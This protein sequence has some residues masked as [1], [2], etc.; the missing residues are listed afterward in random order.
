MAP[1]SRKSRFEDIARHAGVGLATVDRVLNERGGVSEKTT[2]KVLASARSLGTK[3]VLPRDR[4]R[5]L[6]IEAV[7]FRHHSAFYSRLNQAL[8]L[9]TKLADIPAT[10]YRTHIDAGEPEQFVSHLESVAEN[11]DGIILFASDLPQVSDAINRLAKHTTIVTI[12]TDIPESER[13][14][15]IGIDNFNAGQS[16]AKISEAICRKGGRILVIEPEPSARA[17]MERFN[18]FHQFFTN[19]GKE[20]TLCRFPQRKPL[21]LAV[22][23]VV[24]FLQAQEDVRVLYSPINN[25][26]LEM[27]VEVGRHETAISSVAKIVHDLSPHS[28]ENLQSGLIDIVLD[29]NPMQQAFQAVE[30]IS[31]QHGHMT[32]LESSMVDF[33]LYTS[34]NLP[35][36]QFI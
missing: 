4:K 32:K 35:R 1:S 27:L 6:S 18:G 26:F 20:G 30:F 17:Q 31:K 9:V 21:T 8:K 28:I 11:R 3:R 5:R 29:S 14:C 10:I 36:T 12:S 23:E 7:L 25:E 22:S 13:H 2:A 34:D 16:V 15:Y 24:A 19:V 33:H